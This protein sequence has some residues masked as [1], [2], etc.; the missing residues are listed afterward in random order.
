MEFARR[1]GKLPFA[2]LLGLNLAAWLNW[3]IANLTGALLAASLPERLTKGLS[4]SLAAT[5]IGSC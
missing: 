2:W 3:V 5:F 4:F 1:Y